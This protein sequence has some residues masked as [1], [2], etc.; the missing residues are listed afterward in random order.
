MS[1][2]MLARAAIFAALYAA[3]TL[4]PGL[5]G[6]AYGPLQFRVSEGLLPF[7][8]VDPAAVLGLTVG[9]AIANVASPMGIYDVIFGTLFTLIAVAIMYRVGLRV[10][11]LVAPVVV[12]GFGVGV[13]LWLVSHFPLWSSIG[14]VA[15]GEAAVMASAG[16]VVLLVV[17]RNRSVLGLMECVT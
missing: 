1:S 8:C 7:A 10:W 9:T 2:R 16:V 15:L 13:E 6:L 4:A 3:L 5:N 17:R 12:N 11:A 14:W